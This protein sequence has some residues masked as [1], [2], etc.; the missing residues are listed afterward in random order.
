[1]ASTFKVTA[2]ETGD[3]VNEQDT[4]STAVELEDGEQEVRALLCYYSKCIL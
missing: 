2:I 1:M 4:V 3:R